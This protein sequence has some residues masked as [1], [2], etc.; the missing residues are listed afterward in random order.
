M[1][2]TL[3]IDPAVLIGF[4]ASSHTRI[5]E[6]AT[7]GS[8]RARTVEDLLDR[9][10]HL[11]TTM[12]FLDTLAVALATALVMSIAISHLPS[13]GVALAFF[14]AVVVMLVFGR[15]VPRAIAL[16]LPDE[17]ALACAR[18]A[19]I[20][21]IVLSPITGIINGIATLIIGLLHVPAP[22]ENSAMATEEELIQLV[23]E[24]AG[25]NRIEEE[26]VDLVNSIFRFTDTT[27]RDVMAPRV[28]MVSVPRQATV[29]EA[30]DV[31]LEAG[32]SRLPVFEGSLDRIVGIVYAKDLLRFVG[33]TNANASIVAVMRP[34]L[35]V[36]EGKAVPEL[37]RELQARRVH[38]AIV[39]DEYGGTAGLVTIEDILE[40]IVGEIQDEYDTELPLV[41]AVSDGVYIVNARME[42][43]DFEQLMNV[44]WA[45]SEQEREPLAG[46]I[47]DRFGRIP[48][49]GD[50]LWIEGVKFTVLDIENQRLTKL[51]V[52][53]EPEDAP[54]PP[55]RDAVT[56]EQPTTP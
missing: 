18:I 55:A 40:E 52:E 35:F 44:H 20:T 54:A 3:L 46:L 9:S 36:P 28:D 25:D 11:Q 24:E 23:R 26:E 47:F 8:G 45:D 2:D 49:V 30:V 13:W 43:G 10:H 50:E 16:R 39:V 1:T 31:A 5:S 14:L 7:H 32:H 12:I 48:A 53:R 29:R 21:V 17:A 4:A 19:R 34:P 38:I 42:T 56:T 22:S 27:V 37:L 33:R 51:R 41:E 15:A 6:L